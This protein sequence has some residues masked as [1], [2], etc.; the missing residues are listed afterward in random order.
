MVDI[1]HYLELRGPKATLPGVLARR[2]SYRWIQPISLDLGVAAAAIP[3]S[4]PPSFFLS[5]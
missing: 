1:T 2:E 4:R 3:T 5:T